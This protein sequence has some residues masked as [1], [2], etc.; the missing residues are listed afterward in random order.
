LYPLPLVA[1]VLLSA[2]RSEP[3]QSEKGAPGDA[4]AQGTD[5][6]DIPWQL[7]EAHGFKHWKEVG[8]LRFTFNADQ[9]GLHFERSW[10]WDPQE[11]LVTAI[12]GTDTLAYHRGIMDSTAHKRNSGFINDRFWLLA[13]FSLVWDA[14]SYDYVHSRGQ[15]A[16]ISGKPMQKLTIVYKG[17]GGYTPG[18]AYDLYFGDDLILREWV[19]R[20]SNQEQPTLISSWEDYVE[21]EGLKLAQRHIRQDGT[22]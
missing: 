22:P 12:S 1:L 15:K 20:K 6:E 10:I 4:P 14:Q 2:C 8:E 7:A 3:K 16:P 21:V 5:K 17:D 11:D 9:G 19:Y 13:P 18:D